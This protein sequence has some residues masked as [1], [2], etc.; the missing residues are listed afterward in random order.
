ME[1]VPPRSHEKGTRNSNT[2]PLGFS[3]LNRNTKEAGRVST[4]STTDKSRGLFLPVKEP[5]NPPASRRLVQPRREES[6]RAPCLPAKLLEKWLTR[7]SSNPQVSH[8]GSTFGRVSTHV[9]LR[10]LRGVQLD[11][12][13]TRDDQNGF[14][15]RFAG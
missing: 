10:L 12:M 6:C 5:Q 2:R 15:E 13:P 9:H 11:G 7:P 8:I 14:D 4:R 3:N 1:F